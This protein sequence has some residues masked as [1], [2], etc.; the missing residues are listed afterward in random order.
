MFLFIFYRILYGAYRPLFRSKAKTDAEPGGHNG[1]GPNAVPERASLRER[2]HRLRRQCRLPESRV[3]W[4]TMLLA[5]AAAEVLFAFLRWD[6]LSGSQDSGSATIRNVG[7][8]I[9]GSVAF[10][11]AIWRVL[12]ADRQAS[13]AQRQT[14]IAQ[15]GLLNERYQQGAG[16]L[17]SDLLSVRLG[18]V[19]IEVVDR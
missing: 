13:A 11:L 8:V 18:V 17:G 2:M 1:V 14:A 19:P 15:Q 3:F 10:P 4:I 6:W 16:M 9:G 5:I 7:L 12:V